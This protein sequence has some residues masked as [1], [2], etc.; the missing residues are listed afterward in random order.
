MR[1]F[2]GPTNI[3]AAVVAGTYEITGLVADATH[4]LRVEVKVKNTA[5]NNSS[6]TVQ[7]TA[8]SSLSPFYRDVVKTTVGR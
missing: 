2:D 3:T 4:D 7:V 6:I 1:Y 8:L 5:P